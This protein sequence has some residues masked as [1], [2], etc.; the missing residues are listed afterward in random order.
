[1]ELLQLRYFLEVAHTQHITK[2]A[3]RLHISQPSL[4][5]SIHRLE[6]E[7]GVKLF[8]HHGRNIQL[9]QSGLFLQEKLL[10]LISRLDA[11][12]EQIQELEDAHCVTL[13]LHVTAAS[14]VVSEAIIAYRKEHPRTHF[15]FLLHDDDSLND[16]SIETGLDITRELE[17]RAD[18]FTC[19]EKIYLAVPE[20][21]GCQKDTW[22]LQDFRDADFISLIAQKRFRQICDR[23][24]SQSG[25]TPH[26]T[27]ESDNPDTV[28][29]MIS[30]SMGVGFWPAFSWGHVG[31]SNI[32][33]L[34]LDE[35]QCKRC[36]VIR[37]HNNR[38]SN[39]P[40][41]E[42]FSFLS[43]FFVEKMYKS[44]GIT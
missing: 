14:F 22:K 28:R 21:I 7:L 9:T 4:S 30:A 37:K 26:V 11:L 18:V 40:V 32:Q 38:V 25:F 43:E 42:F 44:Y 17:D 39:L 36:I 19:S 41:D 20:S 24:C 33:L 15:Q 8:S 35:P 1:M 13:R 16:M 31:H 2:S 5:Q 6:D 29:N 23:L 34:D 10:P 12:P 27:F 3:E